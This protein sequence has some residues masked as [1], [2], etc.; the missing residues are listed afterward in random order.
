[1]S[2]KIHSETLFTGNFDD[3][4]GGSINIPE[5][6]I[7]FEKENLTT[8]YSALIYINA[9]STLNISVY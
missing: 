9:L 3:S 4:I 7:T 5:T 8:G 2:L 1:M 6:N